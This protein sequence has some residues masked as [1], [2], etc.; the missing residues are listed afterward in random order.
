MNFYGASQG[1]GLLENTCKHYLPTT[2]APFALKL[3]TRTSDV[4][5]MKAIAAGLA[6]GHENR[7]FL[8]AQ[9]E[10]Q[11]LAS[12]KL[13]SLLTKNQLYCAIC[14]VL[15]DFF[16]VSNSKYSN[17]VVAADDVFT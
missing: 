4:A 11:N 1:I 5:S 13:L 14:T 16:F 15:L 3:V 10:M 8:K 9:R 2:C 17:L 6:V 7:A 12:P